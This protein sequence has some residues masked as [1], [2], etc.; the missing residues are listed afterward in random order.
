MP[1]AGI[2]TIKLFD[3][4]RK[5]GVIAPQSKEQSDDLYFEASDAE[6]SRLRKGQLVQFVVEETDTGPE[7]KN[8]TVLSSKA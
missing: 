4:A 5:R 7:A 1:K 2:G 8:V 3:L 6:A